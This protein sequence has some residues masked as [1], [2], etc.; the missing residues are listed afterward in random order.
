MSVKKYRAVDEIPDPR[1]FPPLDREALRRLSEGSPEALL[2]LSEVNELAALL[3]PI[4]LVPGVRKGRS[5]EEANGPASGKSAADR[6][7]YSSL[8]SQ[9]RLD[10]LLEIIANHREVLGDAAT[11]FERAHRIIDLS[12]R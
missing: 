10:L 8:S 6:A 1:V 3:H 4:G 2:R 11:R 5:M 9:E 12:S 7:Y